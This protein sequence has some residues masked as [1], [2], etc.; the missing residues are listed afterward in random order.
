M[1]PLEAVLF[2]LDGTLV[3]TR[4]EYRY[5]VVGNTLKELGC[6][7]A[8][9]DMDRFWFGA[10]RDKII[11]ELF[12]VEPSLFWKAFARYDAA[13]DRSKHTT[14]FADIAVLRRLR[15]HGLRLG[16]VTNA[17][18]HIARAELAL[19]GIHFFDAVVVA[20]P[21]RQIRPKPMPDGILAC[22]ADLSVL[23][24]HAWFVGN[25]HEDITAAQA[26]S[27]RDIYIDRNEHPLPHDAALPSATITSLEGL[28]DLILTNGE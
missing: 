7:A 16:V 12:A 3:S 17:P 10:D 21:A 6:C 19:I 11:R 20:D 22:L 18:R 24:R 25:A 27:V 2:D 14:T 4:S 23:P 15:Q 13:H 8:Q 5:Q 28:F 26:A 1:P 9:S